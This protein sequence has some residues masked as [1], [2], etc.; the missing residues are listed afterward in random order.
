MMKK[1]LTMALSLAVALVMMASVALAAVALNYSPAADALKQARNAVMDKYG[2]TQT[3][4]GLFQHNLYLLDNETVVVFHTDVADA[5]GNGLTGEYTVTIPDGGTTVVSWT[6]DHV[7]PAVWQSGDLDAPIWGQAQ[8]AKFLE[9]GNTG[10]ETNYTASV[11]DFG[12]TYVLVGPNAP[13]DVDET[14]L[15]EVVI[16]KVQPGPDD[17]S[18]AA[19]MELACAALTDAFALTEDDLA[20]ANFFRCELQQYGRYATRTWQIEAQLLKDG[21]TWNVYVVI[22]AATSEIV[23]IG[24]SV[25]SHG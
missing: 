25:G 18:E 6:F 24:M 16:S 11:D 10:A 19:A 22:D 23:D 14:E 15:V 3:T 8:L 1:K 13:T 12:V 2:L 20:Q 5:N 4:L 9:D 7:D 21:C 17:M